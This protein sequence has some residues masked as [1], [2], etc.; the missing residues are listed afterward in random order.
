[1]ERMFKQFKLNGLPLAI[2]E[3][4]K[5]RL[6]GLQRYAQHLFCYGGAQGTG[7]TD[8]SYATNTGWCCD[9]TNGFCFG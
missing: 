7:N 8:N 4:G 2:L 3:A 6:S 1:M 5:V 9:G